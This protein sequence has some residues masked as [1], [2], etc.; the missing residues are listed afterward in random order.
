[1]LRKAYGEHSDYL[2]FVNVNPIFD[3]LHSDPRFKDLL[4][5]MGLPP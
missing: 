1:M 2:I 4:Q 3:P 5:R